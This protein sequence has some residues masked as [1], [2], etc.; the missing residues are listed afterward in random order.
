MASS[1]RNPPANQPTTPS[2]PGGTLKRDNSKKEAGVFGWMGTLSRRKKDETEGM[3]IYFFSLDKW[4]FRVDCVC[5]GF[6]FDTAVDVIVVF[7]VQNNLNLSNLTLND[8]T[9]DISLRFYD[10]AS[11]VVVKIREI[12][13]IQEIPFY[14]VTL[15]QYHA[16]MSWKISL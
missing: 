3:N 15:L 6:S 4:S 13:N 10:R 8:D 1:P 12:Q 9:V 5:F 7:A 16:Q 2:S 14:H 11:S